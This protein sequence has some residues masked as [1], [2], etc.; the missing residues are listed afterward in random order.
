MYVVN[1]ELK[2]CRPSGLSQSA[3]TG[4]LEGTDQRPL[5]PVWMA[6]FLQVLFVVVV[7]SE[8][9]LCSAC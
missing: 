5:C 4:H 8:A 2:Q 9:V 6:P 1:Y 3:G 7:L